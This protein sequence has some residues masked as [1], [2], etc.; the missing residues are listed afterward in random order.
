MEYDKEKVD[1]MILALL[2]LTSS[3]DQFGTR[4]W[5]AFD[6][7]SMDR[8]YKKGCI[9]D[10]HEKSPSLVFS[11]TGAELSRQLFEKH[12]SKGSD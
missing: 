5:K 1:E 3:T 2:H 4:A 10:P 11:K 12:F 7:Q 9:S 6:W 8:L